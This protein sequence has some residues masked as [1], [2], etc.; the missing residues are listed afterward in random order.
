MQI[1]SW[2][3]LTNCYF[4]TL[5]TCTFSGR[6]MKNEYI[7]IKWLL[8]T[9]NI[10]RQKR[11]FHAFIF[12]CVANDVPMIYSCIVCTGNQHNHLNY[13]WEILK[14]FFVRLH[15]LFLITFFWCCSGAVS[16]V[17]KMLLMW[18]YKSKWNFV[19]SQISRSL[20]LK[21]YVINF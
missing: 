9:I 18:K 21:L 15:F 17:E 19:L 3:Q 12:K 20:L 10:L 11:I 4:F 13:W 6:F 1:I 5:N 2:N 14:L 8:E 7:L 16:W